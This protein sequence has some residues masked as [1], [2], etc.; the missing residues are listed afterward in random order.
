MEQL[1]YV[2]EFIVSILSTG[3]TKL[4]VGKQSKIN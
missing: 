3:S 4:L 1:K 2:N